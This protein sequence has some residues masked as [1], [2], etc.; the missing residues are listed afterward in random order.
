MEK[1][2]NEKTIG[3]TPVSPEHIYRALLRMSPASVSV[4]SLENGTIYDV[5]DRFC[6]QSGFSR[7]E[8]IGKS[9]LEL[10]LWSDPHQDRQK[11]REILFRDGLCRNMEVKHRN[12]DGAI[13]TC[14][15]SGALITIGN[16]RYMLTLVMDI[17]ARKQAE[18]ALK[19]SEEKYRF[20]TEK[21]TD[22]VWIMDMDLRTTYVTPSIE[23]VLGFTREE[24][25]QQ[26]VQEQLTPDSLSYVLEVKARELALEE[27]GQVVPGRTLTLQLEYSH[28]DG[29]T[30]WLETVVSGIRDDQGFLTGLY[31][32]SRD[33]TRRKQ[34]EQSLLSE[35]DFSRAVMDSLPGLF[36]IFDEQ[37]NFLLWNK[38]Y[39][40]IT[41]YS[42]EELRQLSVPDQIIESD[43]SLFFEKMKSVFQ[44]GEISV[45]AGLVC[46]DGTV[47][48]FL[49]S[50]TR[51]Q[52]KGRPCLLGTGID[53]TDKKKTTNELK[54]FAESLEDANIAMRV[55]MNRKD[56][57]RKDMEEKLQANVNSLVVPYL[58][59]LQQAGLDD[60]YEKYLN[61]L[62]N[63]LREV[64]SP[65]IGN[66]RSYYKSLTPH[67]IQI[68]DLIRRGRGTKE[69]A[70]MLNASVNTVSAHR[71]NI[72]KKLNLKKVKINL[73]SYLQ[74]LS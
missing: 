60:R 31:G 28:K 65:F 9:A 44:T 29:S 54:L 67:E 72:R 7:E 52:Y 35:R 26:S 19:E 58:K 12:R 8:I 2:L 18:E 56:E 47:R 49:F 69:I 73:R 34:A 4:S 55:L 17:T 57:D 20:I 22:I 13:L 3:R 32:V 21:M 25:L 48:T 40:A 74:S 15:D 42:D 27:Q 5:S 10:G 36:Y 71:N 43:R 66:V 70:D 53:I 30:R 1:R 64:L 6:Q 16:E 14:L 61:I 45:E 37:G 50:G 63:N 23:T 33:I 39:T 46:K 59:M 62:E 41:G 38:N 51:I 68:A 24:R 11:F